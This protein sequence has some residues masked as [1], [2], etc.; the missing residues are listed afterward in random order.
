MSCTSTTDQSS[1]LAF[2]DQEAGEVPDRGERL[3]DGVVGARPGARGPGPT[4]TGQQVLGE[5]AAPP[6]ADGSGA[7]SIAALPPAG[8]QP[9]GLIGGQR[10]CPLTK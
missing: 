6:A 4:L 8:R 5:L 7:A 3:F 2:R 1:L 9:F 10:Q